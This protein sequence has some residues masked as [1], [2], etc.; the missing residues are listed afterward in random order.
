MRGTSGTRTCLPASLHPLIPTPPGWAQ[1]GV[2][3]EGAG[4][5]LLRQNNPPRPDYGYFKSP[6]P[7]QISG[8]GN[9]LLPL[10]SPGSD[11]FWSRDVF[12]EL[13]LA[14]TTSAGDSPGAQPAP[15]APGGAPGSLNALGETGLGQREPR[16]AAAQRGSRAAVG[17]PGLPSVPQGCY[18]S[19]LPRA[20]F[21]PAIRGKDS[22]QAQVQ[23]EG[24][25]PPP[26]IDSL[27]SSCPKRTRRFWG[28]PPPFPGLL[29]WASPR[30]VLLSLPDP[31][32]SHPTPAPPQSL[33]P[34]LCCTFGPGA[35]EPPARGWQGAGRDGQGILPS[36]S[37]SPP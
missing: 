32:G 5:R 36:S 19:P 6:G 37:P 13:L 4:Q 27:L 34:R 7:V 23:A 8:S 11:W 15:P 24:C 14:E 29:T 21:L 3:V 9:S 28:S 25:I 1:P 26:S 33:C 35:A 2:A 20:D 12:C 22:P 30:A 10:F 16:R 18:R 17:P 31:R